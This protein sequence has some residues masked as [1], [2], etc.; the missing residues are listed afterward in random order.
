MTA[1][2]GTGLGGGEFYFQP[3]S[4]AQHKDPLPHVP[5]LVSEPPPWAPRAFPR[6]AFLRDANTAPIGLRTQLAA[7]RAK[8]DFLLSLHALYL[9]NHFL[10][11][12]ILP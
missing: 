12:Y 11:N 4:N 5:R 7:V 9:Q 1:A 8:P 2:V 10:V 3:L 6:T